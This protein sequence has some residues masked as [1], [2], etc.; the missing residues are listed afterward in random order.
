VGFLI[1]NIAVGSPQDVVVNDL[2]LTVFAGGTV[3]LA[4]EQAN[5]VAKSTDLVA[6]V[7]A[8]KLIVLDPLDDTTP[9]TALQSLD[10]ITTHNDTR[11]LNTRVLFH[12]S[13]EP[14]GYVNRTDSLISFDATGSPPARVFAVEPSGANGS[15]G[16]YEYYIRGRRFRETE[17]KTIQLPDTTSLYFIY[18][19]ENQ[20]LQ[21]TT[22]FT[23]D[24]LKIYA[25]TAAIYWASHFGAITYFGDERHGLTMDGDTHAY[26]H[27]TFGAQYISG[28]TLSGTY[29]PDEAGSPLGNPT[30]A[31]VQI[32]FSPGVIQDEDLAHNIVHT[33]TKVNSYD[34]EQELA[35]ITKLIILYRNATV[36]GEWTAKLVPD[37][38]PLIYSGD[39]SGYVGGANGLPPFNSRGGS[40]ISWDLIEVE[41]ESYFFVHYFA[42]NYIQHPVVGVLGVENY[43]SRPTGLDE[44]SAELAELQDFPF[45]E[46][47]PIG[48]ILYQASSTYSNTPKVRAL[49]TDEGDRYV[50][51][52]T[53]RSISVIVR[54]RGVNDHGNLGGLLD[55]DHPQYHDD[56]RGDVR[57][58]TK[59]QITVL[60]NSKLDDIT[61]EDIEDLFNVQY[62]G[63]P[64]P[65]DGNILVW[66]SATQKWENEAPVVQKFYTFQADQFDNPVNSD[67]TVN[68]L[69]PSSA[70]TLNP[71]LPV[72]R[73][74]DT[75]EEGVGAGITIPENTVNIV[76]GF[77]SRAQT[78]PGSAQ[79][80]Q[81]TL[82]N[83]LVPDNAAVGA[84]SSALNLTTI[85]IPT[86][87]NFQY[88]TQT[89]SL[90]TL[91]WS[92]GEH[93]QLEL[94]RRG[95]QPGDTLSGDWNLLE[96][97]VEFTA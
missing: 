5:D 27:R 88:D 22:Q 49:T 6:A 1:K 87:T 31:D 81:P 30:D 40:P 95:T 8:G 97:T 58:Y 83:R 73:F 44:V 35:P 55:D 63:S 26:L 41:D 94:T 32:R 90:A 78:A 91:G 75:T 67:W 4:K 39:S 53:S 84:W 76:F 14:S 19:D 66:N 12:D 33:G 43:T 18:F 64:A 34:F 7:E 3:D 25:Y 11:M 68:S 13:K 96:M 61:N 74:D 23:A 37:A 80:V 46:F 47:T 9:L 85:S 62:V 52:R 48:S 45:Q 56:T 16:Y 21:Y 89:I 70:D 77:K 82:Y 92:A 36:A 60:L 15:P 38:F 69:A 2:G 71:A 72:R 24:L 42:T 65:V 29:N 57:Y 17:R 51:L 59:S 28:L 93:R 20:D 86:N 54:G 10:A 50:D 79:T